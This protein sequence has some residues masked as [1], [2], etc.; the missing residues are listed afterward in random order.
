MAAAECPEAAKGSAEADRERAAEK[1]SSDFNR[2]FFKRAKWTDQTDDLVK[3]L[4]AECSH[5]SQMQVNLQ[6]RGDLDEQK[7]QQQRPGRLPDCP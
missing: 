3:H 2:L 7:G 6:Y 4:G 1:Q 5:R